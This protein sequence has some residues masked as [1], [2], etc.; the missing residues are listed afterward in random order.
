MLNTISPKDKQLEIP[1]RDF[2]VL[3]YYLILLSK[4]VCVS[5]CVFVRVHVK[6]KQDIQ[7]IYLSI[8]EKYANV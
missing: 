4:Y 7:N 5:L 8:Y 3:Y 6:K 1:C 2:F